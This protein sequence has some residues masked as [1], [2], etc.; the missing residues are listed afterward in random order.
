MSQVRLRRVISAQLLSQQQNISYVP[1][2]TGAIGYNY[3]RVPLPAEI[4]TEPG[5]DVSTL[6]CPP[7]HPLYQVL[8]LHARN[9]DGIGS[10]HAN[11]IYP[12]RS[13]LHFAL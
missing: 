3:H 13:K 5:H 11:Y 8:L 2:M 12:G 4:S 9:H 7:L 10:A 6:L 1:W